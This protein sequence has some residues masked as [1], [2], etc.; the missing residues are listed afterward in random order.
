MTRL[1]ILTPALV[2]VLATGLVS[3]C[4]SKAELKREQ[5]VDRLRDEMTQVRGDRADFGSIL[6]ELRTELA[7]TRASIDEQGQAGLATKTQLE[8]LKKEQGA[9]TLRLQAIEQRA[10]DDEMTR[11]RDVEERQKVSFDAGKKLFDNGSF[12]DAAEIFWSVLK[13]KPKSDEARRAQFFLAESY[14]NGK[15]FASAALEFSEFKKSYP[16]DGLVP[17]AIYRQAQAFR[18]M[19][20]TKEAKLFYQE[21]L[22]RF[23]K[24]PVAAGARGELK[25]LK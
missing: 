4:K 12:E 16:K 20:K 1:S 3:G 8:E 10:V 15:D 23:P 11:R 18:S 21:L 7:R 6:E 17:T 24:S 22:E 25:K 13:Q 9:L 14:F 19:G 2:F 5:D